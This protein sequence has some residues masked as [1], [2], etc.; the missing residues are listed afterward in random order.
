MSVLNFKDVNVHKRQ[1]V[2]ERRARRPIETLQAEGRARRPCLSLSAELSKPGVTLI[3]EVKRQALSGRRYQAESDF[4]P[5]KLAQAYVENGAGAVAVLV[6]ELF[7]G[8]T[9]KSIPEVSAAIGGKVPILYK[10]FVVDPYQVLEA[11]A[12]GADAVLII[13]RPPVDTVALQESIRQAHELGMEAMV[14]IFTAEGAREALD[15]GA[16][17]IGINNSNSPMN[18]ADVERY[19]TL[20]STLPDGVLSVSESGLKSADDVRRARQ[21]GFNG[22]L[23]GEAILTSPDV[24]AKVRE[25]SEAGRE[26]SGRRQATPRSRSW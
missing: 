8:G 23:I 7:F 24:A 16:R 9:I 19:S 4:H 20:R 14:E 15:A 1:E 2:L 5:V 6:D 18:T 25:L 21:L 13:A 12:L 3:A 11:H 26:S 17:I 22:V 10:E